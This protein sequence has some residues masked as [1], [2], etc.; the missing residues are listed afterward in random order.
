MWKAW[1]ELYAVGSHSSSSP[2]SRL[3]TPGCQTFVGMDGT[4]EEEDDPSPFCELFKKNIL[5]KQEKT[6]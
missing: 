4:D 6:R 5:V 1:S 3:S 2:S